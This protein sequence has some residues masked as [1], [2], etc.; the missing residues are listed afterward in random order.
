[1]HLEVVSVS[2]EEKE[3]LIIYNRLLSKLALVEKIEDF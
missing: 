1:M 2:T 3:R